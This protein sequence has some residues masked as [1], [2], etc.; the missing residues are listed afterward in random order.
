MIINKRSVAATAASDDDDDGDEEVSYIS[1][2][3]CCLASLVAVCS[4]YGTADL[5]KP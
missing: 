3:E 1:N 5:Q 2:L 4:S